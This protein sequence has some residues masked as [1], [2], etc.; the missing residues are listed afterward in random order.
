LTLVAQ[1][2]NTL[3]AFLGR[4]D[5]PSLDRAGL[6]AQGVERADVI[7]LFGGSIL[8]GAD[9]LARAMKLELAE[10]Y[11]IVGGQGHTTQLL[12]QE[13]HERVPILVDERSEAD[14]LGQYLALRHGVAVDLLERRST[15]CG[16]NVTRCLEELR[17]HSIRH[18][19]TVL[20]QD[21]AMQ[22]RM[23]AG[24]RKHLRPGMR[25]IN[26]A[27][28]AVR[29]VVRGCRLEYEQRPAGMWDL[30][31][32]VSLLLGEI[33]RLRDDEQGY[34]PNGQDFIA[35]VDIP[36]GVLRAYRCLSARYPSLVRSADACWATAV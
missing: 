17:A 35:H 31:Q 1:A 28:Y 15:N 14:L 2:I 22:L 19:T 23:D 7:V 27:A 24:F 4:R 18:D 36:D 26:Y 8:C 20:I 29:V 32:Y 33:P 30:P 21:A 12:R 34:G 5:I 13:I 11:M 25:V 16:T 6:S 10:H 3:A 9:L